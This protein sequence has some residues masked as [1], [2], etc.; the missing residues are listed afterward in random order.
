MKRSNCILATDLGH[1]ITS[2]KKNPDFF[3]G[4][5]GEMSPVPSVEISTSD[6]WLVMIF[7]EY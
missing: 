6:I 3:F 1:V 4:G 2:R 5:G 7:G